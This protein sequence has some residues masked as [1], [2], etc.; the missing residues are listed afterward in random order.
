[1]DFVR[2]SW[3]QIVVD[4]PVFDESSPQKSKHVRYSGLTCFETVDLRLNGACGEAGIYSTA[5]TKFHFDGAR[6]FYSPTVQSMAA[7]TQYGCMR[8]LGLPRRIL[9]I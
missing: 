3:T 5:V 9:P 4:P 7:C 8:Q 6:S 1:M 2:G